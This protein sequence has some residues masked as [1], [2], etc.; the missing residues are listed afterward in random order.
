LEVIEESL[1][2]FAG[3]VVLITHD[4]CL[5]D[6]VCTQVLGLGSGCEGQLYADYS[7]W[8]AAG[9]QA[10]ASEKP[11]PVEQKPPE[12]PAKSTSRKKLS[13]NE[14]RELD[15]M[16]GAILAAEKELERLHKLIDGQGAS[17]D[18][19]HQLAQAQNTVDRLYLRWQ[20]LSE[21]K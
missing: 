20:E 10:K 9:K 6:K 11:K 18:H 14:Q 13:Y 15:G 16:E 21:K 2:E 4:R 8:E 1:K 3:A 17:M 19:Y 5:M 12:E 7:Q